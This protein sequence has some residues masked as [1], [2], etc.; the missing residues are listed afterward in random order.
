METAKSK[1]ESRAADVSG[2]LGTAIASAREQGA[3]LLEQTAHAV[4]DAYDKTTQA[5]GATY[6]HARHYNCENPGKTLLVALG[7]GVG[8]GLLL[9]ISLISR[10]TR[11]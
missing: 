2:S 10:G 11:P 1:L 7:I 4:T 9:G 5:V 3:E 8:L 6:A